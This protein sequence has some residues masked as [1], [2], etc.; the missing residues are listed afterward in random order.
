LLLISSAS[1]GDFFNITFSFSDPTYFLQGEEKTL[2]ITVVN[3]LTFNSTKNI[4]LDIQAKAPWFYANET[5]RAQF[6]LL[7][8]ANGSS[9]QNSTEIT[10][11]PNIS[12]DVTKSLCVTADDDDGNVSIKCIDI[13]TPKLSTANFT[14]TYEPKSPNNNNLTIEGNLTTDNNTAAEFF[15]MTYT[16]FNSTST[17]ATAFVNGTEVQTNLSSCPSGAYSIKLNLSSFDDHKIKTTNN[18]Y[19]VRNLTMN[20]TL[21][22]IEVTGHEQNYSTLLDKFVGSNKTMVIRGKVLYDNGLTIGQFPDTAEPDIHLTGPVNTSINSS[23]SNDG[24]FAI[25]FTG[26]QNESLAT[27]YVYTINVTGI[28]GLKIL[29]TFKIN[30]SSTI[31]L[32]PSEIN[33]TDILSNMNLEVEAIIA[34]GVD[35]KDITIKVNNSNLVAATGKMEL[36]EQGSNQFSITNSIS[37]TVF[38]TADREFIVNIKPKLYT[39]PGSYTVNAVF[40]NQYGNLVAPISISIPE[41]VIPQDSIVVIRYVEY[42]DSSKIFLKA[43]NTKSDTIKV[44]IRENVSKN[45]IS[46]IG[47]VIEK[48]ITRDLNLTQLNLTLANCEDDVCRLGDIVANGTCEYCNNITVNTTDVETNKTIPNTAREDCNLQCLGLTYT[49]TAEVEFTLG[50]KV[51]QDDPVVEWV[52]EIPAGQSREVSYSVPK[53]VEEQ[54]F[55]KPIVTL[56]EVAGEV[57]DEPVEVVIIEP[58]PPPAPEPVPEPVRTDTQPVFLLAF[59]GSLI[60]LGFFLLITFVQVMLNEKVWMSYMMNRLRKK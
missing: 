25:F 36:R 49:E 2:T 58:T 59:F 19:L 33:T 43:F 10:A 45:I 46:S 47:E 17:C 37:D 51:I 11:S 55:V 26:P 13:K 5:S 21:Y 16:V 20:F 23:L 44:T 40:N 38:A 14:I 8:V 34:I 18:F 29:Q 22:S 30:V 48:E 39:R 7:N 41:P 56:T 4:T 1:A 24:S 28:H 15:N 50:Y 35:G 12:W 52:L 60:V 31:S 3:N 53:N 54:W 27:D 57:V 9:A 32:A 6:F 42:G